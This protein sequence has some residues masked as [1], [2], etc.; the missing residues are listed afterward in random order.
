MGRPLVA[1]AKERNKGVNRR[2]K[3]DEIKMNGMRCPSKRPFNRDLD[4][5]IR[6]D[7][8]FSLNKQSNIHT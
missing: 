5:L 7:I 2:K 3:A 4:G 8:E 1:S 6:G